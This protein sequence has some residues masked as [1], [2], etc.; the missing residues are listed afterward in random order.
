MRRWSA[1][2]GAGRRGRGSAGRNSTGRALNTAVSSQFV[3]APDNLVAPIARDRRA[4]TA[5]TI[6]AQTNRTTDQRAPA[7]RTIVAA[8]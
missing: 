7:E 8:A 1:F 6:Q 5:L 4:D 2:T 3:P